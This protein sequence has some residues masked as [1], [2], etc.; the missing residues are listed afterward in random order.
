MGGRRAVVAQLLVGEGN[1]ILQRQAVQ[2]VVGV[3]CLIVFAQ[4]DAALFQLALLLRPHVGRAVVFKADEGAAEGQTGGRAVPFRQHFQVNMLSQNQAVGAV[5]LHIERVLA[6]RGHGIGRHA[7]IPIGVAPLRGAFIIHQLDRARPGSGRIRPGGD[8][9][10]GA[11]NDAAPLQFSDGTLDPVGAHLLNG[12]VRRGIAV[13]VGAAFVD[14]L[15]AA[16]D[17]RHHG[18]VF[19][20][21][22]R[23]GDLGLLR[24]GVQFRFLHVHLSG[25]D[26]DGI[27]QLVRTGRPAALLFQLLDLLLVIFDGSVQLLQ[28]QLLLFQTQLQLIGVVL[29]QLVALVDVVAFLDQYF[30]DGLFRILLD[31]RH[32]LGNDHAGEPIAG[33]NAAHSRQIGNRLH[34]HCR[35]V[36][37]AGRQRNGQAQAQRQSQPCSNFH[38]SVL[39][40]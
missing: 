39:H 18:G 32:V 27:L 15:N 40:M 36:A 8:L 7:V 6:G 38:N 16:L 33:R 37:A 11:L 26:L 20:Q 14:G 35:I 19:Q 29:E 28:L 34:I 22:L 24:L 5:Q 30:L 25:L 1:V 23:L 9:D 17:G 12:D 3:R 31:L 4:R 21:I 2:H 13:S 10:A